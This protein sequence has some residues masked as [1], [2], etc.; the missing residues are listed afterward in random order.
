[1]SHPF[2]RYF[3][4]NRIVNEQRFFST[5]IE[6][7]KKYPSAKVISLDIPNDSKNSITSILKQRRTTRDIINSTLSNASLSHI[8]YWSMSEKVST[9]QEKELG[10]IRRPYPSGG[11]KFPIEL[12]VVADRNNGAELASGIFHYRPDSHSLETVTELGAEELVNIKQ[13]YQAKD[14]IHLPVLLLFT[15]IRER[16]VPKYGYFGEKIA[17]LEA[18]HIAQNLIL[19]AIDINVRTKPLGGGN[20]VLIENTAGFDSYNESLIYTLGLCE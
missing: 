2:F 1:M 16:N 20:D 17:L 5:N 7:I 13:T 10:F 18:G 8:L 14:A 12:Y 6:P 3:N 19:L 11:A 9:C 15:Y 4:E